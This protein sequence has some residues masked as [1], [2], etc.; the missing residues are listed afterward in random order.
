MVNRRPNSSEYDPRFERYM[1]LVPEEDV[2]V[3]MAHQLP[4]TADLAGRVPESLM[5]YRYAPGKWTTREVIGH[6]LDTERIF[7]F[8]VQCFA[9]RQRSRCRIKDQ[10]G[11]PV[12][13]HR[14]VCRRR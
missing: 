14:H 6:V 12:A 2:A 9:F 7:G 8:R 4:A 5:D 11:H 3:A 13:A 1:N 10:G